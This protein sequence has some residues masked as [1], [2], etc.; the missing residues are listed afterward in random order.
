MTTLSNQGKID[1]SCWDGTISQHEFH[2]AASAFA[3]RWNKF[4]AALPQCSW[5]ARPKS[6]Y[7]SSTSKDEGYLSVENVIMFPTPAAESCG[8]GDDKE[9]EEELSCSRFQEDDFIDGATMLQ[10]H[11]DASH[12]Y[13][14]HVVY[15]ASYRVPVLYFRAYCS[16]GRTLVLDDVEKSIPAISAKLLML[17]KWTFITQEDHP[18]LNCP[19]YTLHPCGTSEWMKMLFSYEPAVDDGGV[20][21]A[22]YLV[23]WFSVAGQVFGLKIPFEMLSSIGN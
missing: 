18:Y 7:L 10:N 23:S 17:S 12:H 11:D 4:N 9:G 13:D 1:I 20:A 22:K 6:P 21:V 14:F 3:E 15:N 19:W 5:V 16:D 8:G 2:T